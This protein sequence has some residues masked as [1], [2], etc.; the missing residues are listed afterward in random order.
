MPKR[1]GNRPDRRIQAAGSFSEDLLGQLT[2]RVRYEGS[3]HHKLRPGDYG[4]DPPSN[5]RASKSVCDD[6]RPI[7]LR[8]AQLLFGL[9]ISKGMISR[10][11]DD[12][13]PKYIWA[14]DARGEV[15]EAKVSRSKPD[16]YHGYR[17]GPD[18]DDQRTVVLKEWK[19]R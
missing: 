18:D 15:Y 13:L 3:S 4:F 6:I 19:K 11:N 7:L 9:G 16:T 17:L 2:T 10:L 5:P 14:V 12:G 8:E 1:Q